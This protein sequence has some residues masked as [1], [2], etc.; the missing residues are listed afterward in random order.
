MLSINDPDS[1]SAD[2]PTSDT[3]NKRFLV[4]QVLDK[5]GQEV[6]KVLGHGIYA[7]FSNG[8]DSK[9]GGFSDCP[10]RRE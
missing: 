9:D 1:I 3:S 4:T 6:W 8:T 2:T 5:E 7:T 10:F